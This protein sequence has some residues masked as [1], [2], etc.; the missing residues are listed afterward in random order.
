MAMTIVTLMRLQRPDAINYEDEDLDLGV[1]S[2]HFLDDLEQE[3]SMELR[4]ILEEMLYIDPKK[5]PSPQQILEWLYENKD[6]WEDMATAPSCDD[7]DL[8]TSWLHWSPSEEFQIND[9]FEDGPLS[10]PMQKKV[11]RMIGGLPVPGSSDEDDEDDDEDDEHKG[12]LP[13]VDDHHHH[14]IP[15]ASGVYPGDE[16]HEQEEEE[17]GGDDNE[18][19]DEEDEEDEEGDDVDDDEEEEDEGGEE[20]GEEEEEAYDEDDPMAVSSGPSLTSGSEFV[21]PS[22]DEDIL[23]RGASRGSDS[24]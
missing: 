15:H 13:S 18:H 4:S 6:K 12:S 3:Y 5:R 10:S 24:F 20:G 22:E 16:E 7:F 1:D 14:H 2:M 23:M 21:P 17:E 8:H 19:Y 11:K 9:F